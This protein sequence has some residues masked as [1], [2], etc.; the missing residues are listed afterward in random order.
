MLRLNA[1]MARVRVLI[2]ITPAQWVQMVLAPLVGTVGLAL[3]ARVRVQITITPVII[4]P[5]TL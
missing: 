5:A 4:P 1:L 2:R 3:K